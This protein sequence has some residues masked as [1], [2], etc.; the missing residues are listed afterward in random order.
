MSMVFFSKCTIFAKRRAAKAYVQLWCEATYRNEQDAFESM[1]GIKDSSYE[2]PAKKRRAMAI[3]SMPIDKPPADAESTPTD[4]PPSDAQS[5]PTDAPSAVAD[6]FLTHTPPA[7]A[8]PNE[9]LQSDMA[10]YVV[11]RVEKFSGFELGWLITSNT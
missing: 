11:V 7:V 1:W 10:V 9:S 5:M 4:A 6:F 2:T 3:E 8:D